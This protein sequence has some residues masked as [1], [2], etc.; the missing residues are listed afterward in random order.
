MGIVQT[1]GNAQRFNV[2]GAGVLVSPDSRHVILV[3][4]KHVFDEPTQNWHPTQMRI[5]FSSQENKSFTEELGTPI[6]LLDPLGKNLWSALDDGSDIA[7]IALTP[8]FAQLVTDAVGYQDFAQADDVY[9]GSPVFVFG[10]P[11]DVSPLIGENGLARA[12]TRSGVI[13]WTDPAG[14]LE[15]P[16]LLDS[17]IL[18]GNSGG[19]AFRVPTGL[20]KY[21]S[22]NVGGR[23]AFLGVVT[24]DLSK[25]YVVQADGR[26]IAMKFPDLPVPS[27]EQVQ[28]VGIGGL[29]RVEPAFKVRKLVDEVTAL[30]SSPISPPIPR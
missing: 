30:I 29:G 11:G 25:Y 15:S 23:V 28:V 6:Q 5:R 16:L 19:P 22:F 20:S 9:D 27:I 18:P 1:V 10:F 8:N 14:A 7:A 17:N 4:A 12:V 21:G 3:T 13:A 26:V 2:V 24:A